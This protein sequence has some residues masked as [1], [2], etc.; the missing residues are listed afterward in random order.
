MLIA[1]PIL[2]PKPPGPA[3]G[4]LNANDSENCLDNEVDSD[5]FEPG[6]GEN[7]VIVSAFDSS[8]LLRAPNLARL[9]LDLQILQTLQFQKQPIRTGHQQD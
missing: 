9:N 7:I 3:P 6:F 8:Q 5:D 1:P 4:E 2:L